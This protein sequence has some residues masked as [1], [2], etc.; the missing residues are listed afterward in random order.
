MRGLVSPGTAADSSPS[1][2]WNDACRVATGRWT[3]GYAFEQMSYSQIAEVLDMPINTVKTL[4]YRARAGLAQSLGS[5][6]QE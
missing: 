4:I 6:K 3:W 2:I 5:Q 1:R